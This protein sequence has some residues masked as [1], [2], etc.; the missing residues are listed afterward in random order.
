MRELVAESRDIYVPGVP[1]LTCDARDTA[2]VAY[3][4]TELVR[5]AIDRTNNDP[6]LV[7]RMSRKILIVGA[8]Q[9]G[10][11]LRGGRRPGRPAGATSGPGQLTSFAGVI[12]RSRTR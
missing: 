7:Q 2:S 9:S 1:L 3:I 5:Y 6:A 10:R 11:Q 12:G 4:L 8:V